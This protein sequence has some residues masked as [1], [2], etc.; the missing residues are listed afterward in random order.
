ME[1][2]ICFAKID[3]HGSN[4]MAMNFRNARE[5]LLDEVKKACSVLILF[6]SIAAI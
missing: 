3:V 2:K 1:T 6:Y 5:T 4:K